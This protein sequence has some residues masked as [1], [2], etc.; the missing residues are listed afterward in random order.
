MT[1]VKTLHLLYANFILHKFADILI[2]TLYPVT[3]FGW[4]VTCFLSLSP[5][6]FSSAKSR[7]MSHEQQRS[8]DPRRPPGSDVTNLSAL[9]QQPEAGEPGPSPAEALRV[10]EAFRQLGLGE[11]AVYGYYNV[12]PAELLRIHTQV[13]VG[14]QNGA[15]TLGNEEGIEVLRILCHLPS[16]NVHGAGVKLTMLYWRDPGPLP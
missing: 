3:K 13:V 7:S 12:T 2:S 6:L 8:R 10:R 16:L 4:R 15:L 9:A 14:L 11:G 1:K 5:P